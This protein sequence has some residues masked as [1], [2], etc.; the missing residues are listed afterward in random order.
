MQGGMSFSERDFFTEPFTER[1]LRE[2]ADLA[3]VTD[4]FSWRSPAFKKLGSTP[5]E[6]DDADLI[7]LMLSEPRLIRRPIIKTET[8]I[9]IGSKLEE[10]AKL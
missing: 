8:G 6:L 5:V 9:L 10:L 1:E 7:R 3:S 4:L 2:L